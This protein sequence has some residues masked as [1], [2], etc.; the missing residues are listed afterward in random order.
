[1]PETEDVIEVAEIS[2]AD[3]GSN[4][5]DAISNGTTEGVKLAVNVGAMLLVFTAIVYG[6]NYIFVEGM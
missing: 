6:A 3:M 1:L 2:S 4:A 5:L